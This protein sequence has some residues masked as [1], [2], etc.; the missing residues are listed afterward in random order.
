MPTGDLSR[1]DVLE[2]T[3]RDADPTWSWHGL[4]DSPL[5]CALWGGDRSPRWRCVRRNRVPPHPVWLRTFVGS[6]NGAVEVASEANPYV[7][8]ILVRALPERSS[9][10]LSRRSWCEPFNASFR[11]RREELW[12]RVGGQVQSQGD[13]WIGVTVR[14]S[15]RKAQR[16]DAERYADITLPS[17]DFE[18]DILGELGTLIKAGGEE[19]SAASPQGTQRLP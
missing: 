16:F 19:Q 7:T 4:L 5:T 13:A 15:G 10:T 12:A 3:L 6:V 17:N 18:W 8:R 1:P 11:T 14:A 2:D 9:R